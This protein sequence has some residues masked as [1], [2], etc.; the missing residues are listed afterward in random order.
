MKHFTF[1]FPQGGFHFLPLK[2]VSFYQR[3]FSRPSI[4]TPKIRLKEDKQKD[5][6][7]VEITM[8]KML[9]LF[10]NQQIC[11]EDIHCLDAASKQ[12]LADICLKSCLFRTKNKE[13]K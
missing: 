7:S 6:L 3:A 5:H 8:D 1:L 9:V 11:A 2:K 13:K 10:M 4:N 12:S